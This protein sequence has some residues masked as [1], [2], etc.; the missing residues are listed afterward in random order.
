[1]IKM[2]NHFLKVETKHPGFDKQSKNQIVIGPMISKN[3]YSII[4]EDEFI[5]GCVI[6]FLKTKG[7]KE[8]FLQMIRT[9]MQANFPC[10]FYLFFHGVKNREINHG[11]VI[12]K[13]NS[14]IYT[15]YLF[16][17]KYSIRVIDAISKKMTNHFKRIK[18]QQD[19]RDMFNYIF[20]V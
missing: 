2:T 19:K 18:K 12:V 9:E 13:D 5:L 20:A 7:I 15:Y 14:V 11:G 3:Q 10:C 16:R 8:K 4:I 6:N 1:M 17:G